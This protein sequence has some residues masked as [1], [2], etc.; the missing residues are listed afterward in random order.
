[1]ENKLLEK[2]SFSDVY[3]D[4]EEYVIKVSRRF[5][6]QSF[7]EDRVSRTSQT[8]CGTFMREIAFLKYYAPPQVLPIENLECSTRKAYIK[9]KNGGMEALKYIKEPYEKRIYIARLVLFQG[10]RILAFLESKNVIHA[11]ISIRN[12]LIKNEK[13][14]LI[15]WGAV[16][17]YPEIIATCDESEKFIRCTEGFRSPEMDFLSVAPGQLDCRH[18]IFSLG[19]VVLSLIRGKLLT[20]Q[21]ITRGKAIVSPDLIPQDM[22]DM[23][24]VMTCFDPNNRMLASQILAAKEIQPALVESKIVKSIVTSSV[25]ERRKD[26]V[27]LICHFAGCL[28]LTYCLSLAV[29]IADKLSDKLPNKPLSRRL[30]SCGCLAIAEAVLAEASSLFRAYYITACASFSED[31]LRN[32]ID[33]ILIEL[34]FN[35]YEPMFDHLIHKRD[36]QIRSNVVYQVCLNNSLTQTSTAELMSKYDTIVEH[37]S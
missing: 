35:I 16:I 3:Q 27:K 8:L 7:K 11:D 24:R 19:A 6:K 1:M 14:Y 36:K 23:L 12:I 32:M 15:D 13:I 29:F 37:G 18:D 28:S 22:L 5:E 4:G 31:E 20:Q 17:L 33:F 2:G 9:M 21:D 10:L 34:N 25:T 26:I 30:L